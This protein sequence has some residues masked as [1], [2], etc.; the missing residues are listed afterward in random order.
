MGR[1][2]IIGSII[3]RLQTRRGSSWTQNKTLISLSRVP[4]QCPQG[5]LLVAAHPQPRGDSRGRHAAQRAD[6]SERLLR[7]GPRQ[8]RWGFTGGRGQRHLGQ[9]HEYS[10]LVRT[11]KVPANCELMTEK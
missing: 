1:G 5:Y 2:L 8:T 3:K 11:L 6:R 10:K 4:L 9:G 7:I